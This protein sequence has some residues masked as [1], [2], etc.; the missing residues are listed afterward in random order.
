MQEQINAVQCMQDYIKDHLFEEIT[1]S[2]LARAA[3]YSPWHARRIF[4]EWT[5]VTPSDYIRKLRLRESALLLR[6]EKRRITDVAFELGFGSV[7]GYTRAFAREFGCNPKEYADNPVPL[8]L[9]IPYGVKFRN[10][11]R[12]DDSTQKARH[13]FYR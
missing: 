8:S 2:Q 12:S 11:K 6:D 13:I 4:L 5:G 3:S 1:I 9:F 7:D 10:V